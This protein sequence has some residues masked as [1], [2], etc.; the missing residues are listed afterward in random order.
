MRAPFLIL[1]T[2]CLVLVAVPSAAQRGPAGV[3]G[4]ERVGSVRG[5]TG[6]GLNRTVES[7]LRQRE[8]LDLSEDQVAELE[9]LRRDLGAAL[10]PVREEAAAMRSEGSRNSASPEERREFR[11]GRLEQQRALRARVDTITASFQARFEQ[12]V[13]PLQR[14]SL[15]RATAG[16]TAG[17]ARGLARRAGAR[18]GVQRVPEDRF[19]SPG[20]R[21][22]AQRFR[23]QRPGRGARPR[24]GMPIR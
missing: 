10:D 19:G 15:G 13:P 11:Q 21:R 14:R 5:G 8:R 6:V 12:V 4:A 16:R 24:A 3:R 23:N 7:A 22:P 1:S 20:A 2:A 17:G 18:D 9:A